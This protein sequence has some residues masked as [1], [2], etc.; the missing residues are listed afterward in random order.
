MPES[1]P[2]TSGY[3]FDGYH[4]WC[5]EQWLHSYDAAMLELLNEL[6][7]KKEETHDHSA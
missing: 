2:R 6:A 3:W 1:A 4:N 7:A 5:S